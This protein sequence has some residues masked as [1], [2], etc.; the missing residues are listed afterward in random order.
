[1]Q[2]KYSYVENK[3]RIRAEKEKK[4][5]ENCGSESMVFSNTQAI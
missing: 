3:I 4:R 1:M 5:K 2:T